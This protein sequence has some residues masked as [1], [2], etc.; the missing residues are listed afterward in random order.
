MVK[1]HHAAAL[2]CGDVQAGSRHEMQKPQRFERDG[3]AARVGACDNHGINA[4]AQVD[5]DGN[6]LAFVD[7]GMARAQQLHLSSLADFRLHR[8]HGV[9]QTRL[10]KNKVDAHD[11][12]IVEGDLLALR[13]NECRELEQDAL[14]LVRLLC[15]QHLELVVGLHHRHGLHKTGR[16]RARHVVHKAG[17]LGAVFGLDRHHIAVAAQRD[18]GVLQIFLV[19]G[20][21]DHALQRL[22]DARGGRHDLAP[23]RGQLGRGAVGD[24]VLRQNGGRDTLFKRFLRGEQREHL[25][26]AGRILGVLLDIALKRAR[27][28]QHRGHAQ[29]LPGRERRP[30]FR[31]LQRR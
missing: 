9:G 10:G 16:A 15:M 4:S 27:R 31:A 8:I 17:H 14:D 1:H 13:R 26:D 22:L 28:A 30:F 29:Q 3:L 7:E 11:E 21:A 2:F 24:L 23:D 18:N 19:G 20:R 25:A 5:V 12:V 6:H